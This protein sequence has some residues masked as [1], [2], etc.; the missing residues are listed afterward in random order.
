MKTGCQPTS[1][2]L[3]T[4]LKSDVLVEANPGPRS[5]FQNVN[6]QLGELGLFGDVV[7]NVPRV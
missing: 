2:H 7:D 4:L 6:F 5:Y 1:M 3:P